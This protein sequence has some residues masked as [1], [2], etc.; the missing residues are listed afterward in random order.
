[1][2]RAA[3]TSLC[4]CS[5]TTARNGRDAQGGRQPSEG[6]RGFRA[7]LGGDAGIG[8]GSRREIGEIPVGQPGFGTPRAEPIESGAGGDAPRPGLEGTRGLEAGVSAM[9]APEGLDREVL[10]CRG[11]ADDAQDPAVD[12]TL[13]LA[14]ERFE[15]VEIALPEPIQNVARIDPASFFPF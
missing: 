9:D 5:S 14:E 6:L 3:A 11:I 2:P 10:G 12:G 7:N 4:G 13:M 1:M 15:G 8:R